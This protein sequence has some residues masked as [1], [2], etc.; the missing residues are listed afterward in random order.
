MK[1]KHLLIFSLFA[2]L[3]PVKA[4][5]SIQNTEQ[6]NDSIIYEIDSSVTVE[7]EPLQSPQIEE[8]EEFIDIRVPDYQPW[9]VATIQGKLKMQGLPLSPTL[10]IFMQC[11]S[12]I[13]ISFRAP[14]IGEAARIIL[15]QDSITAVNKL[16]KTYLKEGIS[17]FLKYYPGG[18]SDLQDLLL[19]RVFIPGTDLYETEITEVADFVL[20]DNQINL[21]PKGDALIPGIKYGYVVDNAFHPL[22]LIILPEN[23]PDI[24]IAAIYSYGLRDYNIQLLYQEGSLYRDLSLELKDPEWNGE[25]PRPMDL[26]KKYKKV[27]L[28]DFIRSFGH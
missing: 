3:F 19:A 16:N 23:R 5:D 20:E 18:L 11:D 8:E 21:V 10:K 4:Q 28:N 2:A 27:S 12:L 9:Q 25:A 26:S 17:E 7:E 22:A 1:I 13:D 24:E 15:T 14:L 6:I